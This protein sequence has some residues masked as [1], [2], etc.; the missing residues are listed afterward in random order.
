MNTTTMNTTTEPAKA[1]L[2]GNLAIA[3]VLAGT[4]LPIAIGISSPLI[5]EQAD[6]WA[7]LLFIAFQVIALVLGILSWRT[8][9][10]RASAIASGTLLLLGLLF[11]L[12]SAR[13][14]PSQSKA[15]DPVTA[16]PAVKSEGN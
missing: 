12:M 9:L 2:L 1:S 6:Q 4:L 10:G 8:P 5:G 16:T 14:I 3:I 15:I 13:S 11:I 7:F